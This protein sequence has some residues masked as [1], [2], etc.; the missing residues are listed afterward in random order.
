[1]P[2]SGLLKMFGTKLFSEYDAAVL[3]FKSG[4]MGNQFLIS[5][6]TPLFNASYFLYDI[7]I[8]GSTLRCMRRG[9]RTDDE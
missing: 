7:D 5:E 8:S 9:A 1:M 6:C 3:G 2:L 4:R